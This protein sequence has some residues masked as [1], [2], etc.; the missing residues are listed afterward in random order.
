MASPQKLTLVS[1]KGSQ[2]NQSLYMDS[3]RFLGKCCFLNVNNQAAISLRHTSK[4]IKK[5]YSPYC[6]SK[7]FS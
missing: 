1:F 4:G 6:D 5:A 7:G 3:P 2:P